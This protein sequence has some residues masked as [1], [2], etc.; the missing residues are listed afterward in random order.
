MK[1]QWPYAAANHADQ[2]GDKSSLDERTRMRTRYQPAE[3]DETL[4]APGDTT[5][6]L[7]VKALRG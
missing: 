4:P 3:R 6:S 5:I 1:A 2:R 7:T